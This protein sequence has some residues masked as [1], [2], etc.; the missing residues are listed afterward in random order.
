MATLTVVLSTPAY[1]LQLI[2]IVFSPS[3]KI[4]RTIVSFIMAHSMLG[5]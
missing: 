4:V 3:L 2:S 5:L 1:D